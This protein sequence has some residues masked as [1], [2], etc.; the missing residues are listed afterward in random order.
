L[1]PT[2]IPGC[3]LWLDA[4]DPLNNGT[5]PSNGTSITTWYDK[6]GGNRNGTASGTITYNTTGLNSKPAMTLTGSQNFQGAV[7]ITGNSLTVLIV[8]TMN[9][10]TGNNGRFISLAA[11]GAADYN[12][13]SYMCFVRSSSGVA[14]STTYRN[15]AN[16]STITNPIT[17][18]T[19]YLFE[20]WFD[21]T[22]MYI[23]TQSGNTTSISSTASV[24]TFGVANF[25]IGSTFISD[26]TGYFNGF[27]SEILVYNTALTTS[28]RKQL[29]GYL[30]R[31]WGL[32]SNLPSSHPYY[33]SL[34][35]VSMNPAAIPGCVLW[36]DAADPLN[37]GTAPANGTSITTWYDK[38]GGN[39]NATANTGITYN[40]TGLNSKPA[41]TL[42]GS[43]YFT[44]AV[45]NTG[46]TLTVLM[47][48]T[49]N[50]SSGGNGRFI[51]LAAGTNVA[52]YNSTSYMCLVRNS[53]ATAY[54]DVYRANASS[55][56]IVTTYTPYLV[57]TWFDGT[58]RYITTQNGNS[59]SITSAASTGNFAIT[60]FYIGCDPTFNAVGSFN[61]FMSEILVYNTALST[62]QRQLVEDYLSWKWGLQANL[63]TTHPYYNSLI[64]DKTTYTPTSIP[65][66]TLWLDAK[67]PL[68]TGTAPAN[69]TNISLWKDKS[70]NAFSFTQ[71]TSGNQP[72]Y[73]TNALNGN[74][75][76]QFTAANSTYLGG[77]TNFA[78]GTNS[79][80]VFA[81]F[82]W[83]DTTSTGWVFNK[84]L[85][86]GASGRILMG[87]NSSTIT[88]GLTLYAADGLTTSFTD[89]YPANT[90]RILCFIYNRGS[91]TTT[92]YQNGTS[93]I[94]QTYTATDVA[95]SQ[96]NSFNF[97][98]G[99]YN[100]GT[101]GITPP[102]AGLYLNGS[103]AEI[104]NF[105]NSYDMSTSVQQEIEAYLSY[106]WGLQTNL[107]NTHPYYTSPNPLELTYFSP[108]SIPGCALWFDAADSTTIVQSASKVSQ[109]ND[110]SG[111]G[112]SVIQPTSAN[113]PT[114]TANL[115]NGKAGI[116]LSNT[117]WLYQFGNN[118]PNFTSSSAMS[119]F[120][121]VR[122]DTSLP[123]NGWSVVNTMWF[124]QS[125][126]GT[127]YRYHLSFNN[128]TTTGVTSVDNTLTKINQSTTVGYGANAIIGLSWST[129]SGL[130]YVN[131]NTATFSGQTLVNG[132]TSSLMFNI[133]DARQANYMKDIVIYELIGFNT[134]LTTYQQQQI[135]GYLALKWG[136]QTN[137]PNTHPYY[138]SSKPLA[139][140]SS[141]KS[142]ELTSLTPNI[143]LPYFSPKDINGCA[144]WFDA[145]DSTTIVQS[146]SKVSQWNDKSGNGYSVIQPTSA[147]QPTYTTNLLNGKAGVVLSNTSWLYQFGN[148]MP[149][150]TGSPAMTVFCVARNDTTM[151]SNGYSIVN[152]MW[153]TQANGSG[154]YRYHFSFA[155]YLT[156]GVT[157]QQ[158]Y[159]P[160]S[161]N[162]NTT[163]VIGYGANA[164]IGL[165]WSSASNLIYVNG[166]TYTYGGETLLNANNS[167]TVFNFGDARQGNN[168]KD[169]VIYEFVGFNTQLTTYQQQ[170]VE[171]YLAWKWG[172]QTN[173]PGTHPYY[174]YP[175]TTNSPL[176]N[177]ISIPGCLLWLDAADKGSVI[178]Q[179]VPISTA[180][181]SA[182]WIN[183]GITWTAN[184]S[185]SQSTSSGGSQNVYPYLLF[186]NTT[187]SSTNRWISSNTS[188]NYSTST[189][190]YQITT[191]NTQNITNI[192]TIYGD[193]VQILSGATPVI[194][195]NFT[196]YSWI[197]AATNGYNEMPGTFYIC[198]ST[199]DNIWYPLIYINFTGPQ[200]T[201]G[202]VSPTYVIPTST[203][204]GSISE[205]TNNSNGTYQTWG[206]GGNAYNYFR[207]ITTK[208]M[209]AL[210]GGGAGNDGWLSFGKWIPTFTNVSPNVSRWNDKS[211]LGYDMVS[212]SSIQP[213]YG[214][215]S[216]GKPGLNLAVNRYM[217]N[218]NI[219]LP[220]NYSIFAVGYTTDAGTGPGTNRL[221]HGNT[222]GDSTLF[223]G[224]I[225]NPTSSFGTFVGNGTAWNDVTANT[226]PTSS[227]ATLCLMQMTNNNTSTGLLPY[228]N[229]TAQTAKNGTTVAFTGLTIGAQGTTASQYWNGYV[230]EILIFNSVLTST[231]RQ[232]I[233]GYLANKWSIQ[234]SLPVAHPY[235]SL[236]PPI[237]DPY[238]TADNNSVA[239][240]VYLI[241]PKYTGPVINVKRS[242]DNATSDFYTDA[243]QS[244]LTTGAGNTGTSYSTWI[245]ASTGTLI[246]WYDQGSS[247]NTGIV[248]STTATVGTG[249]PV[250]GIAP[251]IAL[252]SG[253]YV[254]YFQA[255][256]KTWINF[257]T[258]IQPYTI[259]SEYYIS[260]SNTVDTIISTQYDYGQRFS[261]TGF[262]SGNGGD[263]Y[264]S[265]SGTKISFVNNASS[266][267]G[268]TLKWIVLSLSVQTPAWTTATTSGGTAYFYRV[269]TD[270]YH[271]VG[272]GFT[273]YMTSMI[274]HNTTMS[275]NSMTSFYNNRLMNNTSFGTAVNVLSST[276]S[277]GT[278]GNTGAVHQYSKWIWGSSDADI[279]APANIYYWFYYS[280]NYNGPPNRGKVYGACDNF[281]CIFF[282]NSFV[283]DIGEGWGSNN[284]GNMFSINIRTGM[285]YVKI[286]AYN[287][288][289]TSNPAGLLVSFYDSGNNFI[290]G[291][292]STWV[293]STST[294]YATCDPYP[295][296]GN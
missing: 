179:I 139:L 93:I 267:T 88:T 105:T 87:R 125:N 56:N 85:N 123:A 102:Q 262:N 81:V 182:S 138:F 146:A 291:T 246:K 260:S 219:V 60:N 191:Y 218:S 177:P 51:S 33:N 286:P 58:N 295:N 215:M 285:N 17:T 90:Y 111:N 207:L 12:S 89:T 2:T 74:P 165:S 208:Q 244:Y 107:P 176:Y 212:P 45:S 296:F 97:I 187:P 54:A 121:V 171:G 259:F 271:P 150:F 76:I 175:P 18:Y 69:G 254:V 226:T 83:T 13:S 132:N 43:Q 281:G 217:S 34:Q 101:G 106:K 224:K 21:G 42:N 261:G 96:T 222:N 151:P 68:N 243:K 242:S 200:L 237:I 91:R 264:Y 233:E 152:T 103:I 199:Y 216:N 258:P 52:D 61:G 28:Q 168:V 55:S 134:Q 126:S 155:N 110:K 122:N 70:T 129:T 225:G 275:N 140:I 236:T 84:S 92:V 1:N 193:W 24:G 221:I 201:S 35:R 157:S 180:A 79:F 78:T 104:L 127:I 20:T 294:A 29:E 249:S 205:I 63:P 164:I 53:S 137:L 25:S 283:G 30:S 112:Y 256:N 10:S 59:T 160:Y 95:T 235:Y 130:I 77:P 22:N 206:Y 32:Q 36:F 229:G 282:N 64:I 276:Y 108:T 114:Y 189:G 247:G 133:G 196:L 185:F 203:K 163:N 269:G 38:S 57:E 192:G 239:Y 220:T 15:N 3:V 287:G 270:G 145:A 253:K 142:L 170:L 250:I 238:Q 263:W 265:G 75:A 241:F 67:D 66:C 80:A 113:Q 169:I 153:F 136:L 174:Y 119:V 4:A 178:S 40:T 109:W 255:A 252:I 274:C 7:S 26:G 86:G 158:S 159:S 240:G 167:T 49:M 186:N 144:L 184:A 8:C 46:T 181:T 131:G 156:P 120:C 290:D 62:A 116:S 277:S 230:A 288:G 213:S 188:A 231:Q 94:S 289:T 48:C 210:A 41:M 268:N 71:A 266:T 245:G 204:S 135:E 172:L 99:G 11:T 9:S 202:L 98:V 197:A 143:K 232:Y 124:N 73:V 14:T 72:T 214:T 166:N 257:T 23:T 141:S 39:R 118:M 195:I 19:P 194:M 82:K 6:S 128:G 65:G 190:I 211:D 209:G 284:G 31:K 161:M 50:S 147:N 292:K 162:Q 149:A 248:P 148:N 47:V 228:F 5:A 115:L 44:G 183:N 27:M 223:L 279:S 251:T 198:G 16:I 293:Y 280:F 234:S 117:S 227:V 173:L 272:R 278:W 37:T 273:G 154:T 100:N